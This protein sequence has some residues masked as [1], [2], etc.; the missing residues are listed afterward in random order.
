MLTPYFSRAVVKQRV[1]WRYAS[2]AEPLSWQ[3][4]TCVT[5]LFEGESPILRLLPLLYRLRQ[6]LK[7]NTSAS[8]SPAIG[9]A[10]AC[11]SA[12]EPGW[13]VFALFVATPLRLLW[14]E[15]VWFTC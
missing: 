15:F 13:C 7:R 2:A 10:R 12:Y 11:P 1:L 9:T 5:T 3:C 14:R 4:S 6:L 8:C